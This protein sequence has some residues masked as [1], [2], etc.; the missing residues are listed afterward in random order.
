MSLNYTLRIL[1][2]LFLS[3]CNDEKKTRIQ[4]QNDNYI[5]SVYKFHKNR[6]LQTQIELGDSLNKIENQI[7]NL[8][9]NNGNSNDKKL[10]HE[11]FELHRERNRIVYQLNKIQERSPAYFRH[12]PVEDI[13]KYLND[14]IQRNLFTNHL[15]CL[16]CNRKSEDLL[17]IRFKSPDHTWRNLMGRE[18][19]LSICEKCN[20]PVEFIIECMN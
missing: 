14:T 8:Y 4:L 12:F 5:D 13:K 18:G 10:N 1:I 11:K 20:I 16:N 17:W 19:S 3:S 9:I 7:K 15:N 2:L 6:N